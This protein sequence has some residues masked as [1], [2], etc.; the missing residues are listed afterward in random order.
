MRTNIV[1]LVVVIL[2]PALLALL[3][4]YLCK[5]KSKIAL[6]LPIVSACVFVFVGFYAFIITGI[7]FAIYFIVKYAENEKNNKQ[8]ELDK[9]NIQDLE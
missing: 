1:I 7:L 9:M 4:Y 6:I 2:L 5:K 8:S 3:Q